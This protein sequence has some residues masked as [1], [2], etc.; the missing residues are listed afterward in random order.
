MKKI[1]LIMLVLSLILTGCLF[2]P[3]QNNES[4]WQEAYF[5]LLAERRGDIFLNWHHIILVDLDFD[6]IPE[7]L[8]GQTGIRSNRAMSHG[9]SY[10][11]GEVVDIQ[12]DFAIPPQLSLYR[13]TQTGEYVWIAGGAF[14]SQAGGF[15]SFHVEEIDFSDFSN[16]RVTRSLIYDRE[17]IT[18]EGSSRAIASIYSLR[19]S[20]YESVEMPFEEIQVLREE[21]FDG[22]E[23]VEIQMLVGFESEE[24]GFHRWFPETP[25]REQMMELFGEW[26]A[27]A[28]RPLHGGVASYRY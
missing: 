3:K 18:E 14:S 11:N 13:N 5:E 21:F 28:E 10:Q 9:I 4:T 15:W 23:Q 12:F 27:F 19:L 20:D 2:S 16:V 26:H 7:I 24:G 17:F 1:P 25:E 8:F 22:Y 6:G